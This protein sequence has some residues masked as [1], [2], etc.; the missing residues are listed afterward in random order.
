MPDPV[1]RKSDY[2]FFVNT[3]YI[4]N[5]DIKGEYTRTE[6]TDPAY[7]IEPNNSDKGALSI[8]W[9]PSATANFLLNYSIIKENRDGLNYVDTTE[10]DSRDVTI[11]NLL[12]SGTFHLM[13]NLALTTSYSYMNYEIIQDIENHDGGGAVV[14]DF[15]VPWEE[16]THV[17]S[18]SLNYWPT[19][20]LRFLGEINHV[21]S[22]SK[23]I[24]D[25]P[26]ITSIVSLASFSEQKI[27]ETV[28]RLSSDYTCI[29]NGSCIIEFKYA[30]FDD[31]LNNIHDDNQDGDA[32]MIL[33]KLTK[34]WG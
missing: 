8:S 13:H 14:T 26:N 4:K 12:A 1:T 25:H 20:T 19:K 27:T 16:T 10:P 9:F 15:D 11:D 17:Y 28:Y 2:S 33:L 32:Y 6:A 22:D 3:N 34:R 5:M 18:A 7:N 23:W 29:H 24:P 31:V 21:E 30:D